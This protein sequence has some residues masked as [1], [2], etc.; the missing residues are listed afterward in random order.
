VQP[1]DR[2]IAMVFQDYALYPHMSVYD[3]LGFG[4]RNLRYPQKE[5]DRRIHAA[6]EMLQIEHLLSRR[7]RELSGG[8]RQRVAVGRAIVRSP[9]VFLFDEPL[10]NLDA[11]LRVQMR[12]ELQALHHQLGNTVIYVTHDQVEAMTLGDRIIV[13]RDGIVQ[14]IGTPRRVYEH[15]NNMFVAAFIGTPPMNL[16]SGSVDPNGRFQGESFAVA[17]EPA[18]LARYPSIAGRQVV[19]GVRAD[20]IYEM[21][22][23]ATDGAG[24]T[25][26]VKAVE[27]LGSE[28]LAYVSLGSAT[29]TVRLSPQSQVLPGDPLALRFDFDRVSFFDPATQERL[30]WWP[31]ETGIPQRKASAMSMRPASLSG[32]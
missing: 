26:I 19:L 32:S 30:D 25:G 22:S 15:P 31:E 18:T 24:A 21:R 17:L 4:L 12:V 6:A 16:I 9:K 11:K 13:L 20:D 3:N 8:Q 5:I 10:S 27:Y 28:T 2:D 14:Q 7:P 1:K 29:V 23:D